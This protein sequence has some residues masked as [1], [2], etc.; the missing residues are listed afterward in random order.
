MNGHKATLLVIGSCFIATLSV[1]YAAFHHFFY[2]RGP[3]QTTLARYQSQAIGKPLPDV[4]LANFSGE[5][6]SDDE[7]RRGEVIL[8][9]LSSECEACFKEGRFLSDIIAKYDNLRFYGILV[10]WSERN[11][12]HIDGKFPMQVFFDQDSLLRHGLE[13]KSVPLKVFLEDGVIKK[14]RAGA[15]INSQTEREFVKDL[16]ELSRN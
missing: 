3:Q 16:E 9:L 7:L 12:S 14:I 11:I 1:S 5:A 6:L 13:V 10:F 2:T 15:T 8:V 4:N